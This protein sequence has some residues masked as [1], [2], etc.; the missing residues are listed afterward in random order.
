MKP[1]T[2]LESAALI[3]ALA[4]TCM[5]KAGQARDPGTTP[6]DGWRGRLHRA[7]EQRGSRLEEVAV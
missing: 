4:C 6:C 7:S 3:L 1:N 5:A 2:C